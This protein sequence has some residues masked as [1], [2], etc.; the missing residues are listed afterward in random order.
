M[1]DPQRMGL[2]DRFQRLQHPVGD[3]VRRQGAPL[4]EDGGQVMSLE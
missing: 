1:H 2:R 4:L 3:F